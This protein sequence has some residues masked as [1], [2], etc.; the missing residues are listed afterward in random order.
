[1][2]DYFSVRKYVTVV[3][4]EQRQSYKND[5]NAEYDEY[6]NLHARIESINQKFMQFDAQRKLL[7][8]GSK[9]YKVKKD[10]TVKIAFHLPLIPSKSPHFQ[11]RQTLQYICLLNHID[12][13]LKDLPGSVSETE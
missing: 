5:F 1:M 7:S 11:H 8:P 4:Y 13:V 6:R 9:E 10:K 2:Y 3:S 12:N